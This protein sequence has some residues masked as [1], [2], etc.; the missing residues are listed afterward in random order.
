VPGVTG[1]TGN[2]GSNQS[3]SGYGVGGGLI[4]PII[5]KRLDFQ[6][7]GLVGRGIARYTSSGGFT[8]VAETANGGLKAVPEVMALVGATFHVTPSIDLYAF[9]GVEQ[10]FRT[11]SQIGAGAA[12]TFVGYG[13]PGGFNNAGC[14]IEGGTCSGQ[15]RRVFQLTG[16]IW[17]KLYKGNFGEVRVGVQYS[18]TQRELFGSTNNANGIATAAAPYTSARA[19]DNTVLTSFRYYPF[20]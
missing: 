18:Y 9:G 19:N 6:V 2:S 11:Y 12:A 5:P 13:A 3:A 14:Q 7:S 1:A 17:D 4:A 20:Q 10:E 15:Q 8:D 16:G